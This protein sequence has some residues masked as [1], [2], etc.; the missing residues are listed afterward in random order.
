MYEGEK[1]QIFRRYICLPTTFAL[2]CID[3][4]EDDDEEK[5]VE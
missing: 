2:H 3:L 4:A 1:W 5:I